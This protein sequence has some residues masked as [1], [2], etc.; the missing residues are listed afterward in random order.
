MILKPQ[1][2][3]RKKAAFTE[4]GGGNMQV[5]SDFE[6][7]LTQT[8]ENGARTVSSGELLECAQNVLSPNA[9]AQLR[10]VSAD[11]SLVE[12]G[13]MDEAHFEDFSARC[14]YLFL[15]YYIYEYECIYIYTYVYHHLTL[16]P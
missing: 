9:V 12:E 1:E 13:D 2:F 14:V 4:G 16:T 3:Y 11:F 6:H 10:A 15:Y 7:V 8:Q 5:F